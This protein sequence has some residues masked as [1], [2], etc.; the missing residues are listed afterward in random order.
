[1]FGEAG[2]DR[3]MGG[4][5]NDFLHGGADDD[6]LL[7]GAGDDLLE[8]DGGSDTLVG[9]AQ[10][11]TLYGHNQAGTTDDNAVDYLYGDFATG[12]GETGSG[13]DRLFGGGGN[14]FLYGEADDDFIDAGDGTNNLVDFGSGDG[15]TPNQF[16]APDVDG[17]ANR[18]D[19]DCGSSEPLVACQRVSPNVRGGNSSLAR[20]PV[21]D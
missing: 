12:A 3:L 1:M 14:D 16:V 4:G 19:T 15:A 7:G 9:E 2:R 10:H 6:I 21:Q 5:G 17:R 13:R 8:G 18:A 20:P 11:D